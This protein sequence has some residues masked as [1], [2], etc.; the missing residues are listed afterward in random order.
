MTADAVLTGD[1]VELLLDIADGAVVDGLLGTP[2]SA[3]PAALLPP[4]LRAH[5]GVFVTL[6]VDGELNGCIGSIEGVEPLAHGAARHAWSAAFADPRLPPLTRR[7]YE[8]LTLEVSILSP[9]A[10]MP[11]G[12]RDDVLNDLQPGI[13]GLVIVA[14]RHHA[15]FLPAVWDELPEPRQFLDQLQAKAGLDRTCWPSG[16]HAWRFSAQV[17]SRRAGERPSRAA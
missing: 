5:V 14:G 7:D 17:L 13:D 2:P 9:L 12:T 15:V 1:D 3:P 6:S 4:A 10:A 8:R 11:A 16:M